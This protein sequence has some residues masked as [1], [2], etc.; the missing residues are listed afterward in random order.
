MHFL[1][2]YCVY[3]WNALNIYWKLSSFWNEKLLVQRVAALKY[4]FSL[5]GFRLFIQYPVISSLWSLNQNGKSGTFI[6][7]KYISYLQIK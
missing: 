5:S 6:F 7:V 3:S 1:Y 4:T 2:K